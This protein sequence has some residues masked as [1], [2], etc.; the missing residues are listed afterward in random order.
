MAGNHPM[1]WYHDYEGGRSFY[2]EPGH[3]EECYTD[4]I[5]LKHILGGIKYAMGKK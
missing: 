3:T 2:T 1:S 5:Y 4:P